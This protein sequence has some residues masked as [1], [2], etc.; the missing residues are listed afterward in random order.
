MPT[1]P[2]ILA[3]ADD[4]TLVTVVLPVHDGEPYLAVAIE[5]ILR[6]TLRDLELIVIDDGSTDGS[7]RI[8]AGFADAR[9]RLVRNESNLGLVAT[10]NKGLAL[11]RGRYVARMDA[12]DV[13]EPQRFERQVARFRADATI[14]ALGTAITFIDAVGR[15]V[16]VPPRQVQG[17]VQ[18]RWRLLRGT[19]LYHPTLMID[20]SRAG[21]DARY[22]AEFPHAEDYELL[23]RLSRRHELDNLHE[24]LLQ[25]RVHEG[26]VSARFRETQRDSAAR[27]LVV[28]VR[29]VYGLEIPRGQAAALLDPRHFFSAACAD[30]DTPATL[31]PELER[32]FVE[33]EPG[34]PRD[35]RAAVNR[36]VAF[37]LWTL[38]A[39]ALTDWS[40]GAWPM[41]RMRTVASC[42]GQLLR[43]PRAALAALTWR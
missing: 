27:A 17:A 43:R 9:V 33:R 12:D 32:R 15:I 24:R 40:A 6:Q 29:E 1:P 26:S 39:I 35:A 23:L 22:A 41:R 18:L 37:F 5:S 25:Q 13:A 30:V 10:L 36:D 20:R 8:A 31:L 16:S 28:H 2:I 42:A 38:V 14:A 34:M 4:V 11:A 19:C 21:T 3:P 7:A